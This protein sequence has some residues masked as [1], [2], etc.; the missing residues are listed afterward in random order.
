MIGMLLFKF[1]LIFIVLGIIVVGNGLFKV[2][3][4]SLF[5]KCYLLKDLWFDGVFILFYMLINI[6]LLIVLLLVF[7]IVDRFGYLVIYN[8][9][10]VGLIIVLLVY[11]VC[12]GMVKDI[13]FEFDF[14]LMSFSKL[15]Y[16]LF[17]SVVMIFVCAW[18]MYN[19]EVVN[20]VL[21]VFFI[22]V[23]IIFFCQ[24]FKLDKIGCNKMFVVFVLMFEVVVFYI[25]YVQMLILLNFFVINNVYYEI[26]GFFINLVSFQVFNLFWVVFVSLILVGI[27]MYLGNKGK[28]FLMLMKF[29]FGM[30]MCFLGF[31]MVV[32]VGMWFVD[33]QGLILLW[34]IV[35]VY[36]FQSLGELFI[37]VF[38]LVMIVVLVLQYLMGFIF[39]MWFLM[40]VV[41]FLL[42]G[43]VV[44]FIVVLDNIIDLFEMLFVYINV[45]GKIGLVILG[46]VVVMLLMVLWLKCMIVMLESY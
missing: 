34:F 8:L 36:L 6:G 3:L 2:N 27:Y 24:V 46:V 19:V 10:G 40:Q 25:F 26:F 4:V 11:I 12:C 5:L 39:G 42:G 21:I 16:V 33:V 17:G 31:L 18:L 32:V 45:F 44:I 15:L 20:L 37:S 28:D 41:V 13:G 23:I 9:C 7:V 14:K 22:V 30:F 35:L 38:G 1:D 43:Y 29:I